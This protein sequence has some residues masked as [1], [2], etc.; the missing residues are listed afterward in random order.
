MNLFI[1]LLGSVSRYKRFYASLTARNAASSFIALGW[2]SL[3]S[4]ITIPIYIKL[5]GTVEWGLVAACTSLQIVSS[6]IDAGF[7]QIVPRLAAQEV[8]SQ[9]RLR[10]TVSIL[11]LVYVSLGLV[12]FAVLQTSSGYLSNEWFK[13]SPEKAPELELGIRIISFQL[14]FQFIN[15]LNIGLWHGLQ[16]QVLANIRACG[17]GTLKH[18]LAISAL[19][20]VSP[21]VW[22]YAMAFAI[23][24][25]IELINNSRKVSRTLLEITHSSSLDKVCLKPALKEVSVLSGGVL[26]GLLV[27]QFDRIILS[28][29]L[30]VGVF[31]IYTLIVTLALA[32]LQLQIPIT[33]AYF[34]LLVQDMKTL[35]YVSAR[36]LK[37]IFIGTVLSATLPALL[38]CIFARQILEFWLHDQ[39]M[40]DIGTDP[41]RLLLI[42]VALNSIYG[43]IY[44]IIIA[45]G[46]SQMVLRFNIVCLVVAL[47]VYVLV[48]TAIGIIWG[49]VLW[50][51][52][53]ITQLMLGFVWILN[54]KR[55]LRVK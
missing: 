55:G 16:H 38:A 52:N 41:L 31:G 17:F 18:I 32:F 48:P 12:M 45:Q 2:L 5:L 28:H 42:A 29:T 4:M 46:K 35:G 47:L 53:T 34:P 50:I 21:E 1:N 10:Q 8:K 27:S 11:R 30:D 6:F 49:G 33:R 9:D 54:N 39:T 37:N 3:L 7:S 26:I 15:N 14:L 24:A 36:H 40:V 22:V 43:C 13:V 23:S 19:V 44:Q 51:S 20:I 25:L